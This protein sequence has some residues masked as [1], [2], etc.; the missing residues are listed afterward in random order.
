MTTLGLTTRRTAKFP[1]PPLKISTLHKILRD[2]YYVGFV[3]Y[4]GQAIPG[5]HEPIVS[6]ELFDRV[7]EVMNSRSGSTQKDRAH[8]H[9]L[10]GMLHCARCHAR[11]RESVLT[12]TLAKGRGDRYAYYFCNERKRGNCDLSYLPVYA[13][14]DSIQAAFTRLE[15]PE[16]YIEEAKQQLEAAAVDEQPSVRETKKDLNAKIQEKMTRKNVFS[17]WQPKDCCRKIRFVNVCSR[18][19]FIVEHYKNSLPTSVHR[20]ISASE[21]CNMSSISC[22]AC[23]GTTPLLMTRCV[24]PSTRRSWRSSTSTKIPTPRF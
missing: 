2:Q 12:Y 22:K 4:D 16:D 21:P 17:T 8:S 9:Y 11:G 20:W 24:E 1:S 18:S 10:R 7:Q 14:E 3:L 19:P 13:V 6:I 15:L 23:H 5:R